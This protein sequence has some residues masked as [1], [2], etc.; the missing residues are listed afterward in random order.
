MELLQAMEVNGQQL[1]KD[2]MLGDVNQLNIVDEFA[3][4]PSRQPQPSRSHSFGMNDQMVSADDDNNMDDYMNWSGLFYD[5][6]QDP[7][8]NNATANRFVKK[9]KK[10]EKN[11]SP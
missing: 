5:F 6:A 8:P 2:N 1:L 11:R 4:G 3:P 10:V 7:P 9:E